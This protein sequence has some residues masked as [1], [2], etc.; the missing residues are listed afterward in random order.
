M[1]P[2]EIRPAFKPGHVLVALAAFAAC[3]LAAAL[4]HV[5]VSWFV[6]GNLFIGLPWLLGTGLG[7]WLSRRR[8]PT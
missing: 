2:S 1:P 4:V 7:T 6:P 8:L 3:L 5:L